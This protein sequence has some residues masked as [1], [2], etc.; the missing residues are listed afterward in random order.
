MTIGHILP[1][2]CNAGQLTENPIANIIRRI[3]V[4]DGVGGLASGFITDARSSFQFPQQG[5]SPFD[6]F[7]GDNYASARVLARSLPRF[8]DGGRNSDLV[9]VGKF[10]RLGRARHD[11]GR[12]VRRSAGNW[13]LRHLVQ[14]VSKGQLQVQSQTESQSQTV[15]PGS[16]S[17]IPLFDIP[18]VPILG[19]VSRLRVSRMDV[20]TPHYTEVP[21]LQD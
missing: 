9:L 7:Q 13:H 15:D 14:P 5:M 6:S 8:D 16:L 17:L 20:K 2:Y 4:P 10:P 21:R 19:I 1:R 12:S 11:R 3:V 18:S